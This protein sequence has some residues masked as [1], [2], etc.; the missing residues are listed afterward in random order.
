MPPPSRSSSRP[1]PP[2]KDHAPA[3][4]GSDPGDGSCDRRRN[5]GGQDVVI[6]HMRKLVRDHAFELFIV[7]QFHQALGNRYGGMVRVA[8]SGKR[9][10]RLLWNHVELRHRQISLRCQPLHHLIQPGRL[11]P[12]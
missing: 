5:G 1:P 12:G 9:I 6:A 7:H 8:A 11:L 4:H 3:A 10:R 2:S